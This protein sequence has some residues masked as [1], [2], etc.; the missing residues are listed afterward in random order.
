MSMKSEALYKI[1]G[2][3]VG[4][5]VGIIAGGYLGL[6]LGGTLLGGFDIYESIGMEGYELTTYI[7]ALIGA[8]AFALWGIR[9]AMK[10]SAPKEK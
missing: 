4:F 10:L 1:I 3:I 9:I 7:G 8:V 6:V 5:V 2:G